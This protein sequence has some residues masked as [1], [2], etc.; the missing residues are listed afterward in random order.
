MTYNLIYMAKPIYGGWVTF[1]AH[2]S[3]KT[4]SNIFKISKKN[5]N[6]KR[7]YGYG[8][9]Y[10]NKTIEDICKLDNLYIT[11]L[12]KHYYE[13]LN[14]FPQNTKMVIHDPN[15]VKNKK[16][17]IINNNNLINK[18]SIITIRELVQQHLINNFN[19]Q[20][21]L[22]NHPFY[23]YNKN[24]KSMGNFA[25]SISRI[26]FDK[27]TDI[28]LKCNHLLEQNNHSG[29]VIK[30]F[31]AENRIYVHH[32][33]KQYN[34]HNYWYGKYS[35]ELPMVYENKD[36]L[37]GCTFMVDLSVIKGDGG[38]TQYTFLEA[39]Y[40]DCILILHEDWV[41]KSD[42]FINQFNC[43]TV[44]NELELYNILSNKLT[45]NK[46]EMISNAKNILKDH[47]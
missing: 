39:I 31:G 4:D 20:S 22:I 36:I 32:K 21:T 10:Q 17:P 29:K 18:F 30:I 13:Y 46:D 28:I 42:L 38:G 2:L 11:A 23:E 9:F 37:K 25:V 8:T 24:K 45:I 1:T 35:K 12:D 44:K 27:N 15:E 40:N 5:E 19:I 14:Y 41:N 34:F 26:D 33:L 6:C 3:L 16:N 7:S 43:L 47:I